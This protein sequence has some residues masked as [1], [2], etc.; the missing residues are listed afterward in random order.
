MRKPT[1]WHEQK[2][3]LSSNIHVG[4]HMLI[5]TNTILFISSIIH[6][7]LNNIIS[8]H[9]KIIPNISQIQSFL[10][11][12]NKETQTTTHSQLPETA[13]NVSDEPLALIIFH[14]LLNYMVKKPISKL[15]EFSISLK[16]GLCGLVMSE[17]YVVVEGKIIY[18]FLLPSPIF[19]F[20]IL[21][22]RLIQLDR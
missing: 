9:P 11:S 12:P 19:I 16:F 6:T 2:R 3:S 14:F 17:C 15:N 10:F 22:T 20:W 5:T 13:G 7:K 1:C 21:I 8:F 4:T 18:S